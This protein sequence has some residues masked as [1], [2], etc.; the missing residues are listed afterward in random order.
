MK[1]G[2]GYAKGIMC[3]M[4]RLLMIGNENLDIDLF[5]T[6]NYKG[7]IKS[8][9]LSEREVQLRRGDDILK[10]EAV[11][12]IINEYDEEERKKIPYE[13]PKILMITFSSK[14]FAKEVLDDDRLPKGLF[15]DD[16]KHIRTFEEAIESI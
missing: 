13:N 4:K 2:K 15:I 16:L 7:Y 11:N 6:W 8:Y 9:V 5:K 1:F 3:K 10:I 14:E 12:N